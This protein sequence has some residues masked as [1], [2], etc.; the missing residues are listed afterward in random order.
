[1]DKRT[2]MRQG[3]LIL[4]EALK[5]GI[6]ATAPGVSFEFIEKVVTKKIE[7]KGGKPSFKMV[8]GYFWTTCI[9]RNQGVVHGIPEKGKIFPGDLVSIDAGVYYRG[10]HTDM[11]FSFLVP[12]GEGKER[13]KR[14]AFLKVGK[15]ALTKAIAV[16]K[17][18][19]RVGDIS[20]A[21]EKVVEEEGG[22]SCSRDLT[23]HGVGKKLHEDPYIPCL[24]MG[25]KENTPVLKEGMSLAIEV[26]Y[27][28]GRPELVVREDG[29]TIETRDGKI[30]ALFEKTILVGKEKAE[31][32]TPF[33]WEEDVQA[34]QKGF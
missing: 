18:G 5:A 32:V 22:F 9:N 34:K 17:A 15:K 14:E 13:K 33:I 1:M 30:A 24:L 25:K 10:F 23:G 4:A 8:P 19:N 12:G 2:A 28:A 21:I 27:M 16:A 31:V 7:E 26:I 20:A 6:E 3:G 29:W 11:A